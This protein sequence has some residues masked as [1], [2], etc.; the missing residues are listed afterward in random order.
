MKICDFDLASGL[1]E[2][3]ELR[4][5]IG[6]AG[7]SSLQNFPSGG[8]SFEIPIGHHDFQPFNQDVGGIDHDTRTLG[9][10]ITIFLV[11]PLYQCLIARKCFQT[12]L[13]SLQS[14]GA[15]SGIHLGRGDDDFSVTTPE[16][17]TPGESMT[18]SL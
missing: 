3:R 10:P 9:F 17:L 11:C 13:F 6:S 8:Q 1:K 7:S 16:L 2:V 15:D 4:N 14:V 12:F 18:A 5:K